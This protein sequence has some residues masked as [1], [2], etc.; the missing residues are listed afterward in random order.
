MT[1]LCDLTAARAALPT[2][3][4][5]TPPAPQEIAS[6]P[7]SNA[8]KRCCL[9]QTCPQSSGAGWEMNADAP[10]GPRLNC[11]HLGAPPAHPAYL[12]THVSG[13]R[14]GRAPCSRPPLRRKGSGGA[15]STLAGGCHRH[16]GRVWDSGRCRHQARSTSE[17][18]PEATP[19]Q[20]GPCLRVL[21]PWLHLHPENP[22]TKVPVPKGREARGQSSPRVTHKLRAE[23]PPA[24]SFRRGGLP[25]PR[26]L[27]E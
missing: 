14:P 24:G 10:P 8:Q 16:P 20:T 6:V 12:Q 1:F 18:P 2:G 17:L 23:P 22:G 7:I 25:P 15:G 27:C 4:G 21:R 19:S 11:F 5:P 9:L 26:A 13:G 3:A